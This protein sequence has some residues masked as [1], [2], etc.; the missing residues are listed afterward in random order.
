M[1]S[2]IPLALRP[3]SRQS[4]HFLFGP[5][6]SCSSFCQYIYIFKYWHK[7]LL[8]LLNCSVTRTKY[9]LPVL[10]VWVL[11]DVKTSRHAVVDARPGNC[12]VTGRVTVAAILTDHSADPFQVT[13]ARTQA[14]RHSDRHLPNA[15]TDARVDYVMTVDC[16]DN[17]SRVQRCRKINHKICKN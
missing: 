7:L 4:T 3:S 6:F 5:S 14:I 16:L 17:A 11:S 2:H 8:L 15:R 13:S 12:L 9:N 1:N 10:K